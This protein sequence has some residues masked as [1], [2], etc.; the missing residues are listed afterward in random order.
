MPAFLSERRADRRRLG[1]LG[2][3]TNLVIGGGSYGAVKNG[4]NGWIIANHHRRL[5]KPGQ[6][7]NRPAYAGYQ[8]VSE[9]L[10][11]TSKK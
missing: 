9:I 10:V 11:K 8:M 3:E 5:I 4:L 6:T 1:L 2:Y 7:K